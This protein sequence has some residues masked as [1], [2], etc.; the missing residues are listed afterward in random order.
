MEPVIQELLQKAR[1]S[2]L[3]GEYAQL[4]SEASNIITLESQNIKAKELKAYALINLGDCD[5]GIRLL[6]EVALHPNAPVSALY[7]Y[8]SLL[9]A[10]DNASEAKA[11]LERAQNQLPNTFEILHDLA[12]ANAKLGLK[13]EALKQYEQAAQINPNS[14]ELFFNIGRLHDELFHEEKAL[15]CY[16][17]SI[18]IDPS[19]IDP[20]INMGINLSLLKRY[21]ESL[22]CYQK[23]L[24]L[25][26]AHDFLY[27]NSIQNEMYLGIWS[28]R[29][30]KLKKI[31]D[32]VAANCAVVSPFTLL[33]LS[34]DLA[35]QK[36]AAQIYVG[37]RYQTQQ[38]IGLNQPRKNQKIKIAYLSGDFRNHPVTH[39]IAELLELH[40]RSQYEVYAFAW[41]AD[42][43]SR[44]RKR[45][46]NSVDEFV[47]IS[48]L[49]DSAATQLIKN[50]GVDI[51]IDLGG[52]T[53][54]SRT[55]IFANRVAPIQISYLG[56][57]G[58][59]GCD[60]IDYTIAD[61]VLV[62]IE[63]C[64]HYSE[65]MIYMPHCFQV[66]DHQRE[67]SSKKLDRVDFGL[68]DTGVVYCC[69][70]N[71]YK[72][73]PEIFSS[74]MNILKYVEGSILWLHASNQSI[75]ENLNNEA[76]RFGIDS[77][78]LVFAETLPHAE[79]LARY[80]VADLFLDTMPYNAGTTANDALWTG[81]PVLTCMGNSM[82]SRMAGSLLKNLDL[83]ELI[84]YS[85]A[86][87]QT[88]AIE[89]GNDPQKLKSIRNKL[90]KNKATS[91]LFN[92][93]LFARNLEIA[94]REIYRR[95]EAG[96]KVEHLHIKE[97]T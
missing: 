52:Y 29:E 86:E 85:L 33:A 28:E 4:L 91:P 80:Q 15:A 38:F 76:I 13:Q 77:Q 30:D 94:Y 71:N 65:K 95:H 3:K 24:V 68:P 39:L 78:R 10:K 7:E 84:T 50:R 42:S 1:D 72:I 67:M 88:K 92:A 40:D 60:Y 61:E 21:E 69:F 19:F 81:L 11:I 75:I 44:E 46:K 45:I 9:L 22:G 27:G 23:A 51:A 66:S 32:G 12:T 26:P 5:G 55:Q 35:L 34:D 74:W 59:M 82:A 83:P 63:N 53:Q 48:E 20:W 97:L 18:D 70:N 79:Y 14:A 57:M 25:N 64:Q 54:L 37:K 47:D 56:Y 2:L 62:P 17:R 31:I 8:G 93:A 36:R 90:E 87:Y 73:T 49:S 6:R 96:E 58:T 43:Q 16:Q 89:F 41:G